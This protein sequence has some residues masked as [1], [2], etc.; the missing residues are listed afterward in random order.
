MTGN[1]TLD[2]R[3]YA[4]AY[5][6]FNSPD[7]YQASGGPSNPQSWNRYAYTL[8]DPVN[9][10]DPQGLDDED[11]DGDGDYFLDTGDGTDGVGG[12]YFDPSATGG[13]AVTTSTISFDDGSQ[14]TF[15]GTQS[16]GDDGNYFNSDPFFVPAMLLPTSQNNWGSALSTVASCASSQL[17][18]SDGLALIGVVLGQPTLGAPGKFLGSTGGTS[19]IS[20]LLSQIPW[21]LPFQLPAPTYNVFRGVLSMSNNVGRIVGR[22]IPFVGGA[23]LAWDAVQIAGCAIERSSL[24]QLSIGSARTSLSVPPPSVVPPRLQVPR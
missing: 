4:S 2:Q 5:G 18:L 15:V 24:P 19:V 23:I 10:Y 1:G 13:G 12:G 11:P 7:P 8:G 22:W 9:G 6:R 3:Y 17:G 21:T 20:S 14:Q 16:F